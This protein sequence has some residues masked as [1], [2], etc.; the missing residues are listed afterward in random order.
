M[1]WF[2]VLSMT[3]A[4][5]LGLQSDWGADSAN[6]VGPDD[7]TNKPFRMLVVVPAGHQ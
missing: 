4:A 1:A 2:V 3:M 6:T 7:S 5:S